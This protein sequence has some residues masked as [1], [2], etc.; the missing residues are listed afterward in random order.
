MR[1]SRLIR[2]TSDG[3]FVFAGAHEDIIVWR[4]KE[5]R[6]EL[7]ATPGTWVGVREDIFH[8]VGDSTNALGEGDVLLLHT[9]GI[10][11]AR[12]TSGE[13]FGIDR[14]CQALER[15]HA[16][17]VEGIRDAI[18]GE[19]RAWQASVEDDMTLLVARYHG[20]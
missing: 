8:S 3:K 2:Y 18:M 14:L 17:P 13:M 4:A 5:N 11:E 20:T 1:P 12:A 7:L 16:L 6:C 15:N 9:D 19:A 10:S